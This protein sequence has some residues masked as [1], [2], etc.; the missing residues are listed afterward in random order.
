V[1]DRADV[2][3]LVGACHTTALTFAFRASG[4]QLAV[5]AS[6]QP[7]EQRAVDR[8]CADSPLRWV[9]LSAALKN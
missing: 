9:R 7:G 4:A 1:A 5:N 3:D 2:G 8:L 6:K